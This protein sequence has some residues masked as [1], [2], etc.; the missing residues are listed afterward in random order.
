MVLEPIEA[1]KEQEAHR[2]GK[3]FILTSTRYNHH[4]SVDWGR[5]LRPE[6]A[7]GF[8]PKAFRCFTANQS[9]SIIDKSSNYCS[10]SNK[11]LYF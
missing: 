5:K 1:G 4:L 8:E 3:P 11:Q 2:D 6:P 7:S 9:C 10:K